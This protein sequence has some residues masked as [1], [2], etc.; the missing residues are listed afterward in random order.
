MHGVTKPAEFEVIYGGTIN[1][2]KGEKAGFKII[3][4][5]NTL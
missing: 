4:K 3:G 5:F 2:G 1:T